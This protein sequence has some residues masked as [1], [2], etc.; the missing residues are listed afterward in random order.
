M[1]QAIA[2]FSFGLM[3]KYTL[4]KTD[5]ELHQITFTDLKNHTILCVD[6]AYL[7]FNCPCGDEMNRITLT[8]FDPD[9]WKYRM[10][11]D[12]IT[13]SPSVQVLGACSCHFFIR[14]GLV[15]WA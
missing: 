4:V 9:D 10:E 7:V 3:K 6:E 13:I 11:K 2:G 1:L 15:E 12:G 8:I 14:N 5:K